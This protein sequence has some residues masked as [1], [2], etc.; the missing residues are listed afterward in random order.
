M[1]SGS[2]REASAMSSNARVIRAKDE[3]IVAKAA[4]FAAINETARKTNVLTDIQ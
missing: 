3:L 2:R 1:S 4:V